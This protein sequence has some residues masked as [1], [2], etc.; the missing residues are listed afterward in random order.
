MLPYETLPTYKIVV[1]GNS[2][3]GKTCLVNKYQKM[4][5]DGVTEPT[6]GA[7]FYTK[8]L[9]QDE[10]SIK[11]EI[12]DTAGQE[13]FQSLTKM[14]QSNADGVLILFDVSKPATFENAKKWFNDVVESVRPETVIAFVAN[15]IDLEYIV[16]RNKVNY[17]V[18]SNKLNY[19]ETSEY[20]EYLIFYF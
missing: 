17:Q 18:E 4:D 10:R 5:F 19:Y 8:I 1:V 20:Q 14:Y 13:R 3:V 16:D 9:E 6:V 12:W 15:K 7:E 2:S 11:L